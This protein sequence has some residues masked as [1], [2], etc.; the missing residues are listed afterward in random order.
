M[1]GDFCRR[2]ALLLGAAGVGVLAGCGSSPQPPVAAPTS[3]APSPSS[4]EDPF[5]GFPSDDAAPEGALVAIKEVPVGGAVLV[6]DT[7]LV[8]QPKSGTFKAFSA[9]CPHQGVIVPA[10]ASGAAVL[11]C[12]GHNSQFNLADG[13]LVRGPAT[14]GLKSIPVKVKNGY[15]VET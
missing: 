13:G 3:S 9:V 10:P 7:K 6:K 15:V 14:R 1:S 8:V 4:T 2:R 5:A 12:P 11:E